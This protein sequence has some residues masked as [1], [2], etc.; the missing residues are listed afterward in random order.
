MLERLHTTAGDFTL[1][2]LKIETGRT[3][4]IRVHMQSLGN[5][6]VG[7]TLYGAHRHAS[8]AWRLRATDR[9]CTRNFLHAASL[10]LAHP[11]TGKPLDLDAPL[12]DELTAL[13]KRLRSLE[14]PKANSK[15]TLHEDW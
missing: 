15:P 4:Q 6:V 11:I 2:D 1:L 7:D 12:P 13:L 10:K 14:L 3:H 9:R 5:P 8:P